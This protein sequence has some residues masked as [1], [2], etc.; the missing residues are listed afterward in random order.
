[1][2][3]EKFMDGLEAYYEQKYSPRKAGVLVAYLDKWSDTYRAQLFAEVLRTFSGQY[4]TMPD[5][6]N[7]EQCRPEALEKME[8]HE[9]RIKGREVLQIGEREVSQADIDDVFS[10]FYEMMKE[11]KID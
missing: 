4:K 9:L 10:G 5:I 8:A 11:K 7:F 1:M 3:T 6:A 2:K